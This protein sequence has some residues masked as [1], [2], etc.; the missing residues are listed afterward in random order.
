MAQRWLVLLGFIGVTLI[1]GALGNTATSESVATWYQE[2]TKPSWNPPAW[3]F[4]PVW[5]ALYLMMAVAAWRVW[6]HYEH[7]DR[8][9]ALTWFF[10]Q[11]VLNT[12]WS[13]IFFAWQQPGWAFVE[14]LVLWAALIVTGLKFWSIDHPAGFLW[15]PYVLW[16]SFATALNGTIWWLNR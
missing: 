16:V 4:G 8:R 14:I 13:F 1:A 5:T 7:P 3:L 15:L 11:L 9:R 6:R 10:G 2:L 12:L